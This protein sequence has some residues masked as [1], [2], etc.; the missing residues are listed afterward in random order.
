MKAEEL[1][2]GDWVHCI[3]D[4]VYHKIYRLN[5]G[6]RY[7]ADAGLY[8]RYSGGVNLLSDVE[9]I[10][11]TE[12]ILLLNDMEASSIE[13]NTN[14]KFWLSPYSSF[15]IV[16]CDHEFWLCGYQICIRYVHQLQQAF[17]LA[18]LYEYANNF[19]VTK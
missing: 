6:D 2:I 12:E 14:E 5:I 11:I 16:Q 9:G 4:D 8:E 18:G 3:T 19:K 1:M 13:Q 17:R 7:I 15:S 10:P